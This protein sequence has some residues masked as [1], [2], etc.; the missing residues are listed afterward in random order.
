MEIKALHE[1]TQRFSSLKWL[2]SAR[3]AAR[4]FIS[5]MPERAHCGR[6]WCY[7]A[8]TIKQDFTQ[9]RLAY[10]VLSRY[11]STIVL[12]VRLCIMSTGELRV[13]IF[14][15][16][17]FAL[18]FFSN[19]MVDCATRMLWVNFLVKL[20]PENGLSQIVMVGPENKATDFCFPE[21]SNE[22]DD[23]A[24]MCIAHQYTVYK[25]N[26]NA[27]SFLQLLCRDDF[28][29]CCFSAGTENQVSYSL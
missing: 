24:S 14:S 12:P 4:T 11:L 5:V 18:F 15:T 21:F 13:F 27:L 3:C 9:G 28:S 29:W 22:H 7:Q 2:K 1:I 6:P 20:H 19:L 17:W 8:T 26:R 23:A 10:I 25:L 16:I